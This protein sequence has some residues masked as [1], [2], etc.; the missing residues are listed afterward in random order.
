M[1]GRTWIMAFLLLPAAGLAEGGL[2]SL[3]ATVDAAKEAPFAEI[4]QGNV[5]AG[6]LGSY[7]EAGAHR[8][9][10]FV[11]LFETEQAEDFL[12]L[13]VT[14]PD[15]KPRLAE[16]FLVD[17]VHW[18]MNSLGTGYFTGLPHP[19]TH[20]VVTQSVYFYV[21]H[22][23]RF[24]IAVMS[25]GG[26]SPAAV[27]TIKVER[28]D[29]NEGI[30]AW[31]EEMRKP[32]RRRLG[33]YWED[34]PFVAVH[35]GELFK[36]QGADK[37][38]YARMLDRHLAYLKRVG[39]NSVIY[40]VAWY[41]G[42]FYQPSAEYEGS[43][44]GPL[45]EPPDFDRM[46]ARRYSEAGVDFWPSIRNWN[47]PTMKP[48]LK[49]P[50]EIQSGSVTDYVNTVTAAGT[51]V[52]NSRWH[53]PPVLNALHPRVQAALT[54]LVAEIM[55]RVGGEPGVRG[56]ALFHTI[57]AS[58]GFGT[59]EQSYDDYTL[60]LFAAEHGLKLPEPAGPPADRFRQWHA[61]LRQE[62][63]P[64]WIEWRKQKQTDLI[65]RL[66]TIV[67]A[68]KPGAKLQL[69]VKYPIPTMNV[70]K[71]V[72]NMAAYLDGIGLDVAALA[73]DPN[74]VLTRI[75][76]AAAYQF[77]LRA[78][79]ADS[80]EAQAARVRAELDFDPQWQEPFVGR[81]LGSIIQYNYFEVDFGG[82]PRLSIPDEL[83]VREFAWHVTS[84]RGAGRYALEHLARS[85][86]TYDARY[87]AH[88]GYQIGPQ[89]M[90]DVVQPFAAV[91]QS[92]PDVPFATVAGTN[93]VV[94]RSVA[95]E[96]TRWTYAVNGTPE[97]REVAVAFSASGTLN[98]L[99]LSPR[100]ESVPPGRA[101]TVRL[102]P[103]ELVAWKG[104]AQTAPNAVTVR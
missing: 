37:K 87:L 13:T 101:L 14:Y 25:S 33:V 74:L 4:G 88:G 59:L 7:R 11:Y 104:D 20:S 55:D 26:G 56:L 6:P 40:P 50:E 51:V 28:A 17:H 15:D 86:A 23:K 85:V 5:V 100:S 47:L 57:H 77:D 43:P 81:M 44:K 70:G 54:N 19:I 45:C 22:T 66:A 72:D 103:Y 24:G 82:K 94:V 3:P 58:H 98:R 64:A 2:H 38:Q 61:W 34:H 18:G 95:A 29:E 42:S 78:R 16:I 31:P 10:R 52:T 27:A 76:R 36:G 84:P 62:H 89:F 73:R 91:F 12:K 63:W 60:Q 46:M 83:R 65:A 79:A 68:K 71:T 99:G 30:P 96:G 41:T 80:P 35:G 21:H 67:A 1:N 102:A 69:M 32:N 9:D 8:N 48:W 97:P 92:L 39:H 53:S 75:H 90:E 49:S 93:G